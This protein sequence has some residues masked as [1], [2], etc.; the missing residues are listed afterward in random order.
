MRRLGTRIREIRVRQG[1]TS[2]D[3]LADFLKMHRTFVGHLETGRKDFRMT[4]IIRVAAALDVRLSELFAGLET[5]EE[6]PMTGK[7]RRAVPGSQAMLREID[8]LE[9]SLQKLK[10]LASSG[11]TATGKSSGEP[12]GESLNRARGKAP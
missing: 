1:F 2:Q 5:G 7:A 8:V 10:A 12:K 6:P 9:Q 4:T 3:A 11:K